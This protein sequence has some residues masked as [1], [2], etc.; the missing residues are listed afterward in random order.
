MVVGVVVLRVVVQHQVIARIPQGPPRVVPDNDLCVFLALLCAVA[1]V[2]PQPFGIDA[3][4]RDGLLHPDAAVAGFLAQVPL[5]PVVAPF[6]V[7]FAVRL[8]DLRHLVHQDAVVQPHGVVAQHVG[9]AFLV[10]QGQ[11][12]RP[13]H[14]QEFSRRRLVRLWG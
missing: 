12:A 8:R 14:Q 5:A 3:F 7:A 6:H 10:L 9:G 2:V 1:Q 4:R 13:A 11:G